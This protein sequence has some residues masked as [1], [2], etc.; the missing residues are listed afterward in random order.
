MSVTSSTQSA[1]PTNT[2]TGG[3]NGLSPGA[4]AG[5]I[6]G[7]TLGVF[8]IA[9]L[10]FL[11]WLFVKRHREQGKPTGNK[12]ESVQVIAPIEER[13]EP[14]ELSSQPRWSRW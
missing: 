10:L 7:V 9:V 11:I 4:R 6:V 12:Q 5:M 3:L 2:G 13:T 1:A 14:V 8:I